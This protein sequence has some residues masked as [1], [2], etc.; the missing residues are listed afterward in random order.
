MNRTSNLT[1]HTGTITHPTYKKGKIILSGRSIR[2]ANSSRTLVA[3]RTPRTNLHQ[4][5]SSRPADPHLYPRIEYKSNASRKRVRFR[6]KSNP[7][8]DRR[9]T[10]TGRTRDI[11]RK[12]IDALA[13]LERIWGGLFA[14]LRFRSLARISRRIGD[15]NTGCGRGEG[16]VLFIHG[17]RAE[18]GRRPVRSRH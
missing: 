14:S 5:T 10:R 13:Y 17:G 9:R 16:G 7:K 8:L 6:T 2:N 1:Q 3:N 12:G 18:G 15:W 11:D 4:T